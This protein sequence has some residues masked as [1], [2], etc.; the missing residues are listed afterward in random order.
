MNDGTRSRPVSLADDGDI[1]E[2]VAMAERLLAATRKY[3]VRAD[4]YGNGG[5]VAECEAAIAA[6]LGKERAVMFPTGTLA[7]L[8]AMHC[9]TRGRG[10]RVIVHRLSHL[11]N[12]AGDNL[13]ALGGFTMLPL[14]DGS[15]GFTAA[16]VE[17]EIS[18]TANARVAS[19]IGCIAVESP[20]RRMYGRRFDPKDRQAVCDLAARHGIPLFLDGARMLIECAYSG[21]RPRDMAGAFDLVYLSLYKYMGAPFGCILAGPAALLD[22]IYHERRRH[23]GSLYQ[24][25]PAA[26]LAKESLNGFGSMWA[27]TIDA[28]ETVINRLN[29]VPSLHVERVPNGTNIFLLSVPGQ[30]LDGPALKAAGLQRGL[31]LPD[32]AG[33]R[34]PV[35]VN[36]SWLNIEPELLVERICAVLIPE[37]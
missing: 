8:I 29:A 16:Q 6:H 27:E 19:G 5:A 26:V 1:A 32:P 3:D 13:A 30:T 4:Y 36:E 23:G 10:R 25:W 34:L 35:K 18:R 2:P 20:V 37:S 28:S 17:A 9:L 12:D 7:N 22:E 21:E 15:G 11:F 33:N 31:K 14:D 24:M